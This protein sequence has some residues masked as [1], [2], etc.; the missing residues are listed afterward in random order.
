MSATQAPTHRSTTGLVVLLYGC[1][2][3]SG[4]AALVYEVAWTKML[5]LTFGRTTLAASSVVGGF[6]SG[7][8]LGAWL[9]HRAARSGRN[10][11]RAYAAL[12]IGIALSTA[13]LTPAFVAM[14][15]FFAA[16]APG[17]PG[18]IG[19]TLFRIGFV[20]LILLAPAA[21]MGATYPALCTALIHSRDGVGR[22]LGPVYGLNTIG[23]AAGALVAGFVLIEALGLRGTI[24]VANGVNL[25]IGITTFV[26]GGRMRSQARSVEAIA[27]ADALLPSALPTWVT[28]TI[29]CASGFATLAYEIVWFRAL[30]YLFGNSTYALSIMLVVFLTGLGLGGMLANPAR[31]RASLE[32]TLGLAHV[33]IAILAVVAIGGISVL[34]GDREWETRVSIF[35]VGVAQKPW[36]ERLWIDV[37]IAFAMMLPATLLMGLSFPLA[38]QLFLGDVRRLGERV[39]VA[40]LLANVGSI[41]GSVLAA[42]FLLPVFG[43]IGGTRA[44]AAGSLALGAL[45][46]FHLPTGRAFRAAWGAAALA[47]YAAALVFLPARLP[48][49]IGENIG[50]MTMD[51]IFEE[52]GDLAT[53]QVWASRKHPER[54]MMSVDG[55]PIGESAGIRPPIYAKQILLAHLPMVLSPAT[56]ST[57]NVGLGS[58]STLHALA[59]HPGIRRLD[60]VEI[61]RS[62]VDASRLF[63]ESEVL[64][65]PRV[66]L[67]V[68]DIAHFMLQASD[69]YDLII[70]DGKLGEGFSGNELMLCADFYDQSRARLADDGLFIQWIPLGLPT[71]AFDVVLRTFA[72]R[73]EH[74][75]I[76]FEDPGGVFLA[77]SRVAIGAHRAR[78]F[79]EPAVAETLAAMNIP[80]VRALLSRWVA[81]GYGL[82]QALGDGPI[83]TWDHSLVEFAIYRSTLGSLASA[84][85]ANLALLLDASKRSGPQ[86]YLPAEDPFVVS[87]AL[88]R[89]ARFEDAS[90]E[91]GRALRTSKDAVDAAP[92]NPLAVAVYAEFRHKLLGR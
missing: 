40:T 48:F 24:W 10:P 82:R 52:E 62:V 27:E 39:G 7:M 25:A 38:S 80:H 66:H 85:R 89:K 67:E 92:D 15:G 74:V 65:D 78:A 43:T 35:A 9:Y 56:R 63:D 81:D 69:R 83:T 33:G 73:F 18:G 50:S 91:T 53:V 23:A 68:E 8:G 30:R 20:V 4:G 71:D 12:E 5:A 64:R 46:L 44:I 16:V 86:P 84:R 26:V 45:V 72:A 36:W 28:G 6:M 55:T 11:L 14:P 57:L 90:G 88:V 13:L 41:G 42:V 70:S 2:L 59:Q 79:D 32:R 31:R 1:A 19:L 76:F 49:R 61:S 54:R 29:L 17:L 60:A 22:H 77:G 21:L 47:A 75:A 58:A 34:L 37:A 51:L 87:T 3:F